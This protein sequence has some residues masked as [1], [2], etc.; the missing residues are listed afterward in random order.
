VMRRLCRASGAMMFSAIF[1]FSTNGSTGERRLQQV[2]E[3]L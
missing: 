1:L 2:I 3:M